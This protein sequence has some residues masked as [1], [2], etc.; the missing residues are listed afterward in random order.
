MQP[1]GIKNA[2]PKGGRTHTKD[3]TR[4]GG[5]RQIWLIMALLA[6]ALWLPQAG[7]FI[8]TVF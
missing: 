3:V 2:A 7:Q 5:E 4:E 6:A 1:R 8:E